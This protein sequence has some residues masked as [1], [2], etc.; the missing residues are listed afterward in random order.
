MPKN[1][2]E[3]ERILK[4]QNPNL[5]DFE[6]KTIYQNYVACSLD[7]KLACVDEKFRFQC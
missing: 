3:N 1:S 5:R 4:K 2:C 7:Y 6:K